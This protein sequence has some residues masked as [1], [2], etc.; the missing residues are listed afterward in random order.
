[1]RGYVTAQWLVVRA[2]VQPVALYSCCGNS[3]YPWLSKSPHRLDQLNLPLEQIINQ[4]RQI[5]S[6]GLRFG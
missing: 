3:Q 4:R 6:L 5:N 1:M 2:S